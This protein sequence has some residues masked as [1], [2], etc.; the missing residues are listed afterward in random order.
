[1]SHSYERSLPPQ[2][3]PPFKT[4]SLLGT[5]STQGIRAATHASTARCPLLSLVDDSP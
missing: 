5:A 2:T 4:Y 3:Q 1:M